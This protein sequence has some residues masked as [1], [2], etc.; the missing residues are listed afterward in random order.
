MSHR[1]FDDVVEIRSKIGHLDIKKAEDGKIDCQIYV[2]EKEAH[3]KGAD[4][5]N[6]P[7]ANPEEILRKTIVT[8]T[9]YYYSG[10]R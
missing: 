2:D 6:K 10:V 5:H 8:L 4:A 7:P 3:K 9:H 1:H